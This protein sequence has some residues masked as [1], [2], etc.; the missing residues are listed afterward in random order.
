MGGI[1]TLKKAEKQHKKSEVLK[2]PNKNSRLEF[3]MS[4]IS[5]LKINKNH[6]K[7]LPILEKE[8]NITQYKAC[9]HQIHT[10]YCTTGN[11]D[12]EEVSMWDVSS[13]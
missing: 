5:Q 9:K 11:D 1:E 10:I 2:H 7:L 6:T 3:R 13:Y 4:I 8:S 12:E